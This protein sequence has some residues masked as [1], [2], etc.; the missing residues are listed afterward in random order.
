MPARL[1]WPHGDVDLLVELGVGRQADA[2]VWD[3]AAW[4]GAVWGA[5]DTDTGDWVDVSCD[6]LD[7]DLTAGASQPDGVVTAVDSTTGVVRLAGERWNPWQSAYR[8]ALGPA[9]PVR[10]SWSPV[11]PD[12]PDASPS[13]RPVYT[14]E[15][16][17]WPYDRRRAVVAVPVVD[18]T[19][20]LGA[21]T[22]PTEPNPGV[23]GHETITARMTRILDAARWPADL[24]DIPD[25]RS[26][27]T[28]PTVLGDDAWSMMQTAADTDLG[29]VWVNRGGLVAYRPVAH[30]GQWA[31]DPVGIGL[32]DV[33]GDG[34]VCVLDYTRT[35]PV[36]VRNDVT[37]AHDKPPDTDPPA[38][39]A[40]PD[41]PQVR[42]TDD[43]SIER[44]RPRTYKRTDLIHDDDTWSA[45][46]AEVILEGAAFP[47]QHPQSAT[48]DLRADVR[49]RDLLLDAELTQS[50]VVTDTGRSYLC[51]L[52]GYALTIT[53]TALSGSVVLQDI[54]AWIAGR[55]DSALWDI[56]V[57]GV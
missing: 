57:W 49:V 48:L 1:P 21:N 43:A 30:L 26:V 41:P 2:G 38:N 47:S 19:A 54:T 18:A 42:L 55:W 13:W 12:N 16:D 11:D 34:N 46:L 6:V 36:V 5:S 9:V 44:Y 52:V 31:P 4:D 50:L 27:T 23:G 7:V 29:V 17:A 25:D 33:A 35:D 28:I 14:G 32:T 53:R 39:P 15:S 56:D 51:L 8:G 24:R 10:V 22:L 45:I 40:P 20:A 3:A 37:I